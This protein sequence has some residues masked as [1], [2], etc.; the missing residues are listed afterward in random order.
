MVASLMYVTNNDLTNI[1]G[2]MVVCLYAKFNNL[3]NNVISQQ[4]VFVIFYMRYE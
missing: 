3:I 2:I 1:A 4:E